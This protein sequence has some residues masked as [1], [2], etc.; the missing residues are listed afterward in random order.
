MAAPQV[1]NNRT[2]DH[3]MTQ[4]LQIYPFVVIQ[5]RATGAFKDY[6]IDR[7]EEPK[8]ADIKR[9]LAKDLNPVID[10]LPTGKEKAQVTSS[11]SQRLLSWLW[12]ANYLTVPSAHANSCPSSIRCTG[13][14]GTSELHVLCVY[15]CVCARCRVCLCVYVC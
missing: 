14:L 15:A 9:S 13:C 3:M 6:V 7:K 8:N 11:R 12:A 10:V 1:P 4:S 5:D 2:E